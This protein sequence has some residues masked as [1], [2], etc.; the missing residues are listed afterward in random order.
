MQEHNVMFL[1]SETLEIKTVI[2]ANNLKKQNSYWQVLLEEA[3]VKI[4][5][6][7]E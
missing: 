4:R 6:K 1:I 7:H 5:S 3:E 2:G